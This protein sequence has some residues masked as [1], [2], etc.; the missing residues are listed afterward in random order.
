MHEATLRDRVKTLLTPSARSDSGEP[1]V[2]VRMWLSPGT[3][4]R[5]RLRGFVVH[6]KCHRTNNT[7]PGKAQKGAVLPVVTV[8]PISSF[9]CWLALGQTLLERGQLL[10]CWDCVDLFRPEKLPFSMWSLSPP[11]KSDSNSQSPP[12]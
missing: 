6:V 4:V 2:S 9:S 5:W 10:V 12:H 11:P 3:G 8:Q 7:A 1:C